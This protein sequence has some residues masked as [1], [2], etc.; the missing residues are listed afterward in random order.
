M[1]ANVAGNRPGA[2]G[3]HGWFATRQQQSCRTWLKRGRA[4]NPSRRVRRAYRAEHRPRPAAAECLV[5]CPGREPQHVSLRGS[6]LRAERR[7]PN[8]SLGPT[9]LPARTTHQQSLCRARR[10][11][12]SAARRERTRCRQSRPPQVPKQRL[13]GARCQQLPRHSHAKPHPRVEPNARRPRE[14]GDP[15]AF[16]L[17]GKAEVAGFPP[18]RE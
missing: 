11:S 4:G 2:G 7:K 15:V 1:V 5:G 6:A 17:D 3:S 18:A 14:G 13:G 9:L 8:L 16:A 12:P 10:Q